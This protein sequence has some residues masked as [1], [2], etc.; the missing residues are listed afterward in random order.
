[1]KYGWASTRVSFIASRASFE[2]LQTELAALRAT[3]T[4]Q[5]CGCHEQLWKD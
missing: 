5:R 4:G 1:M 2:F 3:L